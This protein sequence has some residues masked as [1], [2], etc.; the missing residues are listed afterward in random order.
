MAA[1]SKDKLSGIFRLR[2]YWQGK[3]YCRSIGTKS[4]ETA[5]AI[6]GRFENN[7]FEIERGV[8]TIPEGADPVE[9]LLSAGTRQAALKETEF[10]ST[11]LSDAIAQYRSSIPPTSKAATTIKTEMIHLGK[12]SQFL[13]DGFRAGDMS[14]D[15]LQKYVTWRA[16]N[17]ISAETI[18]KE[19]GTLSLFWQFLVNAGLLTKF[20]GK[21]A[22]FPRK[23]IK[24]PRRKEKLPFR[25]IAEVQDFIDSQG[26]AKKLGKKEVERQWESVILSR[27]EIAEILKLADENDHQG[28]VRKMLWIAAYTGM[29]R[30][31]IIRLNV[32]DI[33]LKRNQIKV[34][35][36]KSNQG[37]ETTS[38]TV[39]I[40]PKLAEKL[41]EWIPLCPPTG[42]LIASR[43]K[44][45]ISWD[46]ATKQFRELVQGTRFE[47]LNG[48]HV[49]RHSFASELARKGVSQSV[50]DGWMGHQTEEMRR[51][52][53]HLF[54]SERADG[55]LR[56]E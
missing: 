12:L 5:R 6:Q 45:P 38:R 31:E 16:T 18:K 15:A 11:R 49:F 30:S 21:D 34:T 54:P 32:A 39:D 52:Y 53:R 48:Y 56:L 8:R 51:R 44:L 9:W 14:A 2:F 43:K 27:E 20:K 46:H 1:L 42:W 13:G 36:K 33:N 17:K 26:G 3:Q 40:H 29:R 35:E 25:T 23:S 37:F 19:L 28:H 10:K 22:D 50:I 41:K 4:K 7:V 24:L 55:I 47:M